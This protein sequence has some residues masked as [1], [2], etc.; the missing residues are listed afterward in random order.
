[1]PTFTVSSKSQAR[2]RVRA[3]DATHLV[4]LLD[5]GDTMWKPSRIEPENWLWLRMEDEEDPSAFSHAPTLAHAQQILDFGA[6]LPIDARVVVHCYAGVSRSTAAGLAL[7]L[8]A[9]GVD[10][11][12]EARDWLLS[13]RPRA[14]PNM[15]LARHF[16]QLL[17]LDGRFVLL[18]DRIGDAG[19]LDF[20]K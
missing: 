1:V 2:G 11:V 16:D 15:L 4:S 13:H 9:N 10:R 17:G 5:P 6:R 18:C 7:W 19:I 12:E 8:Q 20:L 3:L 14:S